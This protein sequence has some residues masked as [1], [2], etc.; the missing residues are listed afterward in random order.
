MRFEQKPK[1]EESDESIEKRLAADIPLF[2]QLDEKSQEFCLEIRKINEMSEED[3]LASYP[4]VAK[5]TSRIAKEREMA[6]N[7]SSNFESFVWKLKQE[8]KFTV[9]TKE[10]LALDRFIQ[11]FMQDNKQD[12]TIATMWELTQLHLSELSDFT[13]FRQP[14]FYSKQTDYL[15]DNILRNIE[16]SRF[17]SLSASGRY[18]WEE[19][20]K[21]EKGLPEN[22]ADKLRTITMLLRT[23]HQIPETTWGIPPAIFF[24]KDLWR[25]IAIHATEHGKINKKQMMQQIEL[26]LSNLSNINLKSEP[27]AAITTFDIDRRKNK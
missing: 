22:T 27:I 10:N 8:L 14:G 16:D 23:M 2:E 24:I 7:P 26:F 9:G 15:A 4:E 25:Y 12:I 3:F 11:N 21:N 17:S 20:M 5:M 1:T 6:K 19:T 13:R 18:L